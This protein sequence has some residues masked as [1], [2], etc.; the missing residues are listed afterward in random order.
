MKATYPLTPYRLAVASRTV[1]ATLGGYALAATSTAALS[2][3]LHPPLERVEAVMTATLLSWIIYA[4]AIGWTFFARTA[5]LAWAGV[6]LPALALGAVVY[7]PS[8]WG[9]SA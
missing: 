3:L 7:G 4:M 8:W 2:L 1:A 5:W 6:L 9:V